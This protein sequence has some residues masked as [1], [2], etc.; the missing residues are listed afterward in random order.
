LSKKLH[1]DRSD[2]KGSRGLSARFGDK[3]EELAYVPSQM[4]IGDEKYDLQIITHCL[5]RRRFTTVCSKTRRRKKT[6]HPVKTARSKSTSCTL[7]PS[8]SHT[9]GA[10]LNTG[11]KQCVFYLEQESRSRIIYP[12]GKRLAIKLM[13]R[14][15]GDDP[16][17]MRYI[18]L[19]E[20][21]TKVLACA[22]SRDRTKMAVSERLSSQ[23]GPAITIYNLMNVDAS[24]VS[25][26]MQTFPYAEA[27]KTSVG[28]V[29]LSG[30]H[31]GLLFSGQ[32]VTFHCLRH[33]SL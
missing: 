21:V 14:D 32:R 16:Y 28:R 19:Q 2:S 24:M 11:L 27:K 29:V 31:F 17:E 18:K 7:P 13:D 10:A 15:K 20:D 4:H 5:F 23:K 22:I 6:V 12:I 26:S 1:I 3:G 30:I 8:H 33:R 9:F 25:A